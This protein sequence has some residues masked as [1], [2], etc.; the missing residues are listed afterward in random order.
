MNTMICRLAV[1]LAAAILN[2]TIGFVRANPEPD[3]PVHVSVAKDG[4]CTIR[5]EVD[6]RCFTQDPMSERYLMKVDLTHRS[7]QEL[8]AI[9]DQVA[10]ALPG[11][12]Q[13]AFDPELARQ[14]VFALAFTG[15]QQRPLLKPD[16]PV[17]VTATWTFVPPPGM[18][19]LRV[20][21]LKPGRYSVVVR[22]ELEGQEQERFATLFPGEASFWIR[23]K[24]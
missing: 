8:Q 9:R 20:V 6:P 24:W 17:V 2:G 16:D 21:A 22:Y 19:A 13:V 1:L 23:A 11:W 14:P 15:E 3:I 10:E 4:K 7:A 5:V 18:K 12:V